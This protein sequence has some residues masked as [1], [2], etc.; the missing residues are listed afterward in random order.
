MN[1][2]QNKE[3]NNWDER[4]AGGIVFKIDRGRVL[5]MVIRTQSKKNPF[6]QRGRRKAPV[7][8]FPKGHVNKGEFLKQAALREVEEEARIKA[9]IIDKIGSNDYMIWNKESKKKLKKKVSFFLMEYTGESKM[10]YSD[11][12]GVLGSYWFTFEAAMKKLAYKSEKQLMRIARGKQARM[13]TTK[14]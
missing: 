6:D 7:F 9:R 4:S 3:E 1:K 12:E 5:W 10:R 2:N 13:K 8:K 14:K 11:D